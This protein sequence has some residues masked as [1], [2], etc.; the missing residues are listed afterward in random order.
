M[1]LF[2][3]SL[4]LTLFWWFFSLLPFSQLFSSSARW[5]QRPM[6]LITRVH[7]PGKNTD[8]NKPG[9]SD[10]HLFGGRS[11]ERVGIRKFERYFWFKGSGRKA[12]NLA[13][14]I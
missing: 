4:E 11:N 12:L 7:R 9:S 13:T 3:L 10:K 8:F 14:G 6:I 2:P 1:G 5:K